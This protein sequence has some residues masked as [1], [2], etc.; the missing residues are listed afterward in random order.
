MEVAVDILHK[1]HFMDLFIVEESSSPIIA[2][3]IHEGH[4]I[5]PELLPY[6]NLTEAERMREEDP[7]TGY[8][9]GISDS[10][11]I[12]NISRFEVDMNRPREKAV[13]L[14]P[15][16][17]WGLRVWKPPLPPSLI[18]HSL[19]LYDAFYRKVGKLLR[20]II[21]ARGYFV[22]LDLHSYNY[23][24]EGQQ[25]EST[26]AQEPEINIGTI[27]NHDKWR[28][29]IDYFMGRLS[30]ATINGRHPDVRENVKFKGG[31]FSK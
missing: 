15:E 18:S 9:T 26:N 13:Y 16:D 10:R 6:M 19:K 8:L 30:A 29:L 7:Y 28:P 17:A 1:A 20:H 24:R 23:K 25:G 22:V 31:E 12:I 14:R 3:A 27:H 5:R 4:H 11:V 21:H 2:A